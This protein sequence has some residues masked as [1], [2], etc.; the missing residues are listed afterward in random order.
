MNRAEVLDRLLPVA[1]LILGA[2][3]ARLGRRGDLRRTAA[4][5]LAELK[6]PIWT[7]GGDTDWVDLQVYLGRLRVALRGAGVPELLVRE[8]RVAAEKFWQELVDSLD[9]DI[10]WWVE[11]SANEQ[12]SRIEGAVL[13]WLDR[14]WHVVRRMKAIRVVKREARGRH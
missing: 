14:P 13:D 4:D 7:K 11:G 9:G 3:I 2:W 12:L 6:R 10:G 5:Q 1:T 8:L